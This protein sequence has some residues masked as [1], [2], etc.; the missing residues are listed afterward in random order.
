METFATYPAIRYPFPNWSCE[1][2]DKVRSKNFKGLNVKLF[3]FANFGG[4]VDDL[5]LGVDP[6]YADNW[7]IQ[8]GQNLAI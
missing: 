2:Q 4:T 1:K 8:P 6:C 5:E 7:D 3:K